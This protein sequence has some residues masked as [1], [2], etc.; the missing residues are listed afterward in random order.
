[1]EPLA[2]WHRYKLKFRAF[3]NVVDIEKIGFDSLV[4]RLLQY[5]DLSMEQKELLKDGKDK[6]SWCQTEVDSALRKRLGDSY[7][8]CMYLLV[9]MKA[10]LLQL[11]EMLCL[12][13]GSVSVRCQVPTID[14]S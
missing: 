6:D 11:Q 8:A 13:D 9:A 2:N 3:V 10:D 4:D 7:E 1:M 12:K 5:T 14:P